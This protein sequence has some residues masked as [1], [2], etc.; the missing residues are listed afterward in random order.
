[1]KESTK[2]FLCAVA[3]AV[4]F[5]EIYVHGYNK[6]QDAVANRL[7]LII[8]AYESGKKVNKEES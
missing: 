5:R 1:M 4:I 3:G 7:K 6:G 8:D 2:M